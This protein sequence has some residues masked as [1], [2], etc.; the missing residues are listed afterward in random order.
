[1][2]SQKVVDHFNLCPAGYWL[3]LHFHVVLLQHALLDKI[4]P[5]VV[6]RWRTSGVAPVIDLHSDLAGGGKTPIHK[7]RISREGQDRAAQPE[8]RQEQ[9][10]KQSFP[11]GNS[12]FLSFFIK[13]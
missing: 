10:T 9:H 3:E 13:H 7:P 11:H 8:K 4:G 6:L 2:R 1:S 12:S 5:E